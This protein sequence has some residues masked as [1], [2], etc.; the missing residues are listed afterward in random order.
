MTPSSRSKLSVVNN[1]ILRLSKSRSFDQIGTCNCR[2]S[3]SN[4]ASSGSR[5]PISLSA[6]GTLLEYSLRSTMVTG[7]EATARSS[8]SDGSRFFLARMRAYSSTSANVRPVV[9]TSWTLGCFRTRLACP[10]ITADSSTLASA[11]SLTTPLPPAGEVLQD[12]LFGNALPFQLVRDFSGKHGKQLALQIDRQGG[13]P[14][15]QEHARYTSAAC[16]QNRIVR[17]QKAGRS[18]PELAH[19]AYPHVVTS[20]T[21]ILS[22]GSSATM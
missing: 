14:P 1:S 13:F 5:R 11:A 8:K 18:I 3:A 22:A 2:A 9:T 17:A 20:V 12:F 7:N 19:G 21:I 6:R 4:S 10:P 16:H 15:W